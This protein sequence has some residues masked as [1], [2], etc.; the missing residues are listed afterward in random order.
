MKFIDEFRNKQY[1]K[2]I[3][4]RI[5]EIMPK[6]ELRLMEVCGT[7]TQSFHRFGLDRLI[8]GNLCLIAGPGCPVCV[9]CQ[10]Y[11][12]K[13]I[14]LSKDKDTIILS[15]GDMLRVPG[16]SSSLEKQKAGGSDVRIVYSAWDS[17]SIAK[18]IQKS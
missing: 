5:F 6:T 16:T 7:H 18:K 2:N 11:I 3:S 4:Q 13:A 17:L 15:F 12:D 1:V 8:P 9:S 14:Q 10:D